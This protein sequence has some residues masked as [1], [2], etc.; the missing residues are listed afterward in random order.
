MYMY[1]AVTLITQ[2]NFQQTEKKYRAVIIITIN[3][4][5]GTR[6]KLDQCSAPKAE[7]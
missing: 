3:F 5:I 2:I 7:K 6:L 1:I 4:G